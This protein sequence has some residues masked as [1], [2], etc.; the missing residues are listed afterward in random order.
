[1]EQKFT[2]KN[3]LGLHARSSARLVQMSQPFQA[4]IF[5]R[6]DGQEVDGKSILNLLTLACPFGSE[7]TVRTEGDQAEALMA[8]VE[9]LIEDKFGED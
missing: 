8:A 3:Q 1:M 2:I 9:A 7:I 4:D 6:F 5:V